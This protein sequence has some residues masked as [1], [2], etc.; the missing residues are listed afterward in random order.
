MSSRLPKIFTLRFSAVQFI[1]LPLLVKTGENLVPIKFY[2]Y[3]FIRILENA[4]IAGK[5]R[6]EGTLAATY[7]FG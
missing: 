5:N 4:V 6:L 1:L 3:F 7:D 2:F